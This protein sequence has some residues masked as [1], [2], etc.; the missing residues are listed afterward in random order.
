MLIKF[1]VSASLC[2]ES[3]P[4]KLWMTQLLCEFDSVVISIRFDIYHTI[5]T[6]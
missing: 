4:S 5:S 1:G 6:F 2:D 3:R